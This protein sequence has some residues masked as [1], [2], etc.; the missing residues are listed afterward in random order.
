MKGKIVGVQIPDT[1]P[2]RDATDFVRSAIGDPLFDHSRRF[3]LWGT[4]QGHRR[5][6]VADPE[7]HNVG[8]MFHN[9]GLTTNYGRTDC[10]E[11]DGRYVAWDFL[12]VP[13]DKR[14]GPP[15]PA[16]WRS[17]VPRFPH[18][19]IAPKQDLHQAANTQPG[20]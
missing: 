17:T 14:P 9:L 3:Y 1:T 10:D 6:L 11:I 20:S 5:G 16:D 18:R 12:T 8:A 13:R 7:L 19:G 4:L 2:V 15:Q